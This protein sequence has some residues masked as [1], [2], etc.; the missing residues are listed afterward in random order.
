MHRCLYARFYELRVVQ[1]HYNS[2]QVC[3]VVP[4]EAYIQMLNVPDEKTRHLW[5]NEMGD[6][7]ALLY[8][9]KRQF[10]TLYS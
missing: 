7:R 4:K 9:G 3:I 8:A 1:A 5:G 10:I 2:T 6:R